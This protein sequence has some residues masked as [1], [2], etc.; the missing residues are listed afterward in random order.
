MCQQFVIHR[1]STWRSS[2]S[3]LLPIKCDQHPRRGRSWLPCICEVEKQLL[4][5]TTNWS[6]ISWCSMWWSDDRL[7]CSL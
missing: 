7:F 1:A 2:T 5:P 6:H 4:W 3:D